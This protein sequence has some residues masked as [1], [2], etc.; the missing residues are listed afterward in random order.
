MQ[1]EG[2]K[3]LACRAEET[4][5]LEQ[6]FGAALF[7]RLLA[8]HN[9]CFCSSPL[10]LGLARCACLGLPASVLLKSVLLAA[11]EIS[12]YRSFGDAGLAQP[13]NKRGSGAVLL[14][15]RLLHHSS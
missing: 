5:M 6:A 1:R 11:H 9:G 7:A 15:H 13:T 8:R 2:V 14:H 4:I 10:K 3:D 12:P